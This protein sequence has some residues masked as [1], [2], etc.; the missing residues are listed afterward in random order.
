MFL[1]RKPLGITTIEYYFIWVQV[2][3]N[4]TESNFMNFALILG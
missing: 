3:T 1:H 4:F 2:I